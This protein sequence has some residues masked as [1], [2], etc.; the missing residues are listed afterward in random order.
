MKI[1]RLRSNQTGQTH[2][3]T[4][5]H[6]LLFHF[7]NQT[8]TLTLFYYLSVTLFVSHSFTLCLYFYHSLSFFFSLTLFL[9]LYL[10]YPRTYLLFLLTHSLSF[11]LC[12]IYSLSFLF[13][14]SN[15]HRNTHNIFIFLLSHKAAP[16]KL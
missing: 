12:H 3:N 10:S 2:T 7:Y 14:L 5:K 13:S 1:D 6:T 9:Y 15:S 8:L 4:L 16:S 11:Y